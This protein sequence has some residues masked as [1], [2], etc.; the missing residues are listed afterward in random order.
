MASP[1]SSGTG[2]LR[3]PLRRT[4]CARVTQYWVVICLDAAWVRTRNLFQRSRERQARKMDLRRSYV[5]NIRKDTLEIKGW[6]KIIH[7]QSAWH[8]MRWV[9]HNPN[10]TWPA[11]QESMRRDF[12]IWNHGLLLSGLPHRR[13][14][15]K[16]LAISNSCLLGVCFR[17]W[18]DLLS[19]H[20]IGQESAHSNHW[21]CKVKL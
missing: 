8:Q 9:P 19:T 12:A 6:E 21:A 7:T 18:T 3:P 14:V 2:G 11:S 13:Q 10:Y 15:N 16:P 5:E 17:P 4:S 20:W 1:A